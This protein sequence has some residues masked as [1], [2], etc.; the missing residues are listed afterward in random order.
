MPLFENNVI[1]VIIKLHLFFLLIFHFYRLTP[2]HWAAL[3]LDEQT[4]SILCT[5]VIDI[6]VLDRKGRTP[7][8]L[9]CVE[10]KVY[11]DTFNYH[12][13]YIIYFRV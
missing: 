8:Y 13:S 7:L 9:A 3:Q 10:G 11:I 1:I 5:H 6:D 2:M 4:L 12:Y